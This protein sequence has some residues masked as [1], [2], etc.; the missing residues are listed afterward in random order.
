MIQA[1]FKEK[2][3]VEDNHIKK[4]E[5]FKTSCSIG[6]LQYL[7]D[8]VFKKIFQQSCQEIPVEDMGKILSFNFWKHTDSTSTTNKKYVEPDVWI[9]TDYYDLIIEAKLDDGSGQYEEQWNKEIRSI[10][11]EQV[12]K[13][14]RKKIALVSLGGNPHSQTEIIND[15][16]IYKVSWFALL[17]SVINTKAENDTDGNV[18]RILGDI[19]HLFALQGIMRT[20]WFDTLLLTATIIPNVILKWKNFHCVGFYALKTTIINDKTIKKWNPIN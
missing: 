12:N 9:E 20:A 14:R 7:P 8:D 3:V 13:N 19:I 1:Y 2:L 10:K 11:N 5:D 17:N 16:H 18:C 15:I 4:N 6:L